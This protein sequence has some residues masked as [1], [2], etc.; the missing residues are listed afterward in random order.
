MILKL[1]LP[2]EH[3]LPNDYFHILFD[4]YKNIGGLKFEQK[5]LEY[6]TNV[7]L[8][9]VDEIDQAFSTPKQCT[10]LKGELLIENYHR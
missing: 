5:N 8:L 4:L 3:P 1:L 10:Q 7:N 6:E 2:M 9:T